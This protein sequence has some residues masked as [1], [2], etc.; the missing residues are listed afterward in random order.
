MSNP[1]NYTVG[2]ICAISTERVAAEAFLD[3]KHE[4]PEDVSVHDNNDYALGRMGRHNVVI[5][6][7]PDGEYG[8]ASAA[9]VARDM[10]HTFPNIRIGLMVGIGGGAPSA[11]HDI[12]LGDIVVSAPR[13]G[14]GGVFQYNFGETM[15]DQAFQQTGFLDQPPIIL[16]TAIAGLKAQY[17]AEGHEFEETIDGILAKKRR[18][19]K[20][21][22]RPDPSSDNLF[23]SEIV[24]PPDGR[25]CAAVCLDNQTNLQPRHKRTE[26]DDNPTI[27]Y[28]TIASAN[29]LINN[30]K[31]RD[32]LAAENNVLCFDTEA[33]GLMNHFPC[34]VIR[35]ICDYSDSHKNSDWH[36]YAAM[37]AAAYAKDLLIRIPPR[38]IESEKRIT[39]IIMRV[40]EKITEVDEKINDISQSL[41]FIKLPVAEGAAFDSH[42]EEHNPTCL[43][44]TRV[45]L[46]QHIVSWTQDPSA[47]SIFWLNG[48]A[49]T[50][51]STISRTIAKSLVRT[52]HLGASFFF[53][54]GEGD[55]GSST[56][57]F[58]TI[59][60]QLA[61]M[62]TEIGT[63]VKDA[64]KS[65]SDIG[66]KG[67]REQF[68][69]LIL[70]P[71]S[72]VP[73]DQRKSVFIVIVIDALDECDLE[74]DV[75]LIIRLFNHDKRLGLRIFLTS[76][77]ELPIR[78]GFS[79]IQ[80][81]FQDVILHEISEP[82]IQHDLSVLIKHELQIIRDNY[83]N[84]VQ[85]YR[86][87][88]RD[89]PGQS[90]ID[91]MVKMAVPLFIFAATICRFLADRKCGNPDDQLRK[92]LEYET[93]SQE[94]K[95]DATYLPVLNQ[96]I[97]GLT[98][99]ERNEVLQ[100]FKYIV[101]SIVLLAS[102]LS[103]SSLS[104]LLEIS[105]DVIDTRLDMLHS[106]LS[107][108]QSSE[109]PIRLLH[110][111]FRDFLVDPEKQGLNPFWIDEAETHAK[112]TDNCLQVMKGFLREDMCSLR[113]QGLESS[114]VDREKAATCIP[115]AIQYACLNWVFHLQGANYGVENHAKVLQFLEEHFLHWVEALS[116]IQK[117]P[118]SVKMIASLQGLIPM[119]SNKQLSGFLYDALRILQ[120]NLQL[121]A[122]APLQIYS[123]VLLFAPSESI[124]RNL[125]KERMLKW[126]S[127]EPKV[128]RSW[129]QCIKTLEGHQGCVSSAV[130]SPNSSL[131]A[132][133]S[134][135][136]TIRL[137]NVNTGECIEEFKG[138][139]ESVK[140][141]VFSH[142]SLSV[143]SGS[144][145]TTVRLWC[146]DTGECVHTFEGHNSSVISVAFSRDS[147]FAAS[148]SSD[149]VIRLWRVDTSEC[150]HIL[151][152]P[153]KDG[154]HQISSSSSEDGTI[155]LWH[156]N[157]DN[158]VQKF[159]DYSNKVLPL[160]RSETSSNIQ[161]TT[162]HS[163]FIGNMT[164][165]HDSSL[166][167]TSSY[168]GTIRI[169]HVETGDCVRELRGWRV[170]RDSLQEES[171]MEHYHIIFS[172]DSAYLAIGTLYENCLW[173]WNVSTDER[174]HELLYDGY[175]PEF[176]AFSHDS[177]LIA[178]SSKDMIQ[179]W[180]VNTGECIR[181]IMRGEF[182]FIVVAFSHDSSLIAS[183][184]VDGAIQLW[185]T[186]T[187]ECVHEF[188][189]LRGGIKDM[190]FTPDGLHL[191]TE[192]GALITLREQII[193]FDGYGF[194]K[195]YSWIT[196]NGDNLIW[197]PIEYR[198]SGGA[199]LDYEVFGISSF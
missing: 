198:P 1:E 79:A 139:S 112:I 48:M 107:I 178:S 192:F 185:R 150:V 8:T 94:S 87:L 103:T 141:V 194:N 4:S 171:L 64:V 98:A 97:A 117:T 75:K 193:R 110:L 3:E 127:L 120:S 152:I 22:R 36:G 7:L 146:I 52:G 191:V 81:V 118:E 55:R 129:S 2:W 138:H 109:T 164:V 167:A 128:E 183:S 156:N 80:G 21:Y 27:H 165:S 111:S 19:Q 31:L 195:D 35:G 43:P 38:K 181:K 147:S 14:K 37:T 18:L 197:V 44:D 90:S 144:Q 131:I 135:D 40:D 133:A 93:K 169:W 170:S 163:D 32:R 33:A 49:G 95:L 10:L 155:R 53:K 65:N 83:N 76:R 161:E 15:Q 34:L 26:D 11:D 154:D 23:Q 61:I 42:A 108:P 96:Q 130:F 168:D 60:A 121:I 17:E 115:A 13:N 157:S 176:L 190:S 102:P 122:S 104:Q 137:W 99:K 86:Q 158:D 132:S 6:V 125:F 172:H 9:T 179:L 58:T 20:N 175:T 73:P 160:Q 148:A 143:L 16:R 51:K 47:K 71:L 91:T 82:V 113:L 188:H 136:K 187:G 12:R 134:K 69:E 105:M 106:V 88:K 41:M 39:D 66:N 166:V 126:I 196:W 186:N 25:S 46:L 54:R 84:T 59:A 159:D 92:V 153:G 184:S 101:G 114:T 56:K 189:T 50:G 72:K 100:Q 89:W 78:L 174:V 116:L 57:L 182:S 77:P 149:N 5:A 62:Q 68:N 145:D 30:A 45:E 123:S 24:H 124:V 119:K 177:S 85:G 162:G 151:G 74:D 199:S 180:S 67:L 140:S 70:Q 29:Q 63:H 28:G 173:I 142:D